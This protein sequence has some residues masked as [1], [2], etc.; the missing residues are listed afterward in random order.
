MRQRVKMGHVPGDYSIAVKTRMIESRQPFSFL[1]HYI[2]EK[3]GIRSFR[4]ML[5]MRERAAFKR[6]TRRIVNSEL[7]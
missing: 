6:E 2:I 1:G 5:K 7:N 4:K 3:N